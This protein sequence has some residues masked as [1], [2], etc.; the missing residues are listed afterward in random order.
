MCR[1][2]RRSF[3]HLDDAD[4]GW[5]DDFLAYHRRLLVWWHLKRHFRKAW[6]PDVQARRE[7]HRQA[8][9][10]MAEEAPDSPEVQRMVRIARLLLR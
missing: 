5:I 7:F 9:E 8:V 6:R 3:R 2:L 1:Y 10:W 4:P